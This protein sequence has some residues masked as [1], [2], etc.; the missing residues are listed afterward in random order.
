MYR[1][2]SEQHVRNG[3]VGKIMFIL[4]VSFPHIKLE[5]ERPSGMID[6]HDGH[7]RLDLA[8][9]K[10]SSG[11]TCL[12]GV[13]IREGMARLL[14]APL[15]IGPYSHGRICAREELEGR[16]GPNSDSNS[17]TAATTATATTIAVGCSFGREDGS[18]LHGCQMAKA[19]FLDHMCL[20]LRDSGL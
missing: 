10:L 13:I 12:T 9:Q 11:F 15:H 2:P 5:K 1:H 20:A 3:S 19:R 4:F 14:T 17:E 8:Q 18:E 7:I 16:M 6:P